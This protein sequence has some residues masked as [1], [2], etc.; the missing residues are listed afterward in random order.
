MQQGNSPPPYM[1]LQSGRSFSS[2][3]RPAGEGS[4]H[5]APES[6]AT[7]PG[8]GAPPAGDSPSSSGVRSS[9]EVEYSEHARLMNSSALS[10]DGMTPLI[11]VRWRAWVLPGLGC[12]GCA[13]QGLPAG[14]RCNLHLAVTLCSARRLPGQARAALP[15][16]CLGGHALPS[17]GPPR[18]GLQPARGKGERVML[19]IKRVGLFLLAHWSKAAILGVIITLIVL[20]SVKVC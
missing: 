5:G 15:Q 4:S 13:G 12:G 2:P 14:L 20:V 10:D 1:E 11:Q 17:C 3:P 16:P 18:P 9:S 6:A 7:P 19:F 8:A